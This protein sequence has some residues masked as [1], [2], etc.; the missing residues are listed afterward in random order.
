MGLLRTRFK[1]QNPQKGSVELLKSSDYQPTG[2][3]RWAQG[4]IHD[5]DQRSKMAGLMLEETGI[6]KDAF[7]FH[8]TTPIQI[9][10]EFNQ[11][12]LTSKSDM[13]KKKGAKGDG[14]KEGYG[15]SS[16]STS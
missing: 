6:L 5:Q 2:F 10:G 7:S 11:H 14:W 13:E 1:G 3:K 9:F 15:S 8:N 4:S 12:R 16:S